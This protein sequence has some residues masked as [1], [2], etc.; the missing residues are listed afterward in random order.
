MKKATIALSL[1]YLLGENPPF[2]FNGYVDFAHISRLSD[3]SIID[4]P[5]RMASLDF[6]HQSENLSINGYFA[7]EFQLQDDANFLE[8]KELQEMFWWNM[9][10]LY[11]TYIGS[12]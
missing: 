10:E 1:T 9:R 8:S 5:Y 12:N 4:I 11:A 3:Y 6:N 7:L 2:S